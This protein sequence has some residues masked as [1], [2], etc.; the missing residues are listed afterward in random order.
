M[1]SVAKFDPWQYDD[2]SKHSSAILGRLED[3]FHAL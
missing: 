2:V 3:G 1:L